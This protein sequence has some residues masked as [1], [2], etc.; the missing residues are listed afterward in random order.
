MMNVDK[1]KATK[2]SV[3][4]LIRDMNNFRTIVLEELRYMKQKAEGL[5][6]SW[7]DIQYKQF[8][9]FIADLEESLQKDLEVVEAAEEHLEYKLTLF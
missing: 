3:I 6:D 7:N 5:G 4:K 2:E 9:D 8:L 1:G